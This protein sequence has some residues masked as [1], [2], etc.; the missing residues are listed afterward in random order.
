MI[1]LL[2]DLLNSPSSFQILPIHRR[3]PQSRRATQRIRKGESVPRTA[4][5]EYS[6]ACGVRGDVRMVAKN[7]VGVRGRG[8]ESV[9]GGEEVAERGHSEGL[10]TG[11][12]QRGGRRESEEDAR[13][14]A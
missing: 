10:W 14:R 5:V 8:L 13:F 12:G 9:A 1:M 7:V 6:V 3:R 11:G 2:L 4:V